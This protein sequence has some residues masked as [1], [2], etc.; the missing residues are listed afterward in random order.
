[1]GSRRG[2]VGGGGSGASTAQLDE[3]AGGLIALVAAVVLL[4]PACLRSVPVPG[5]LWTL[6]GMPL[7]AVAASWLLAGRE[8]PAI[9]HQ[10]LE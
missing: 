4:S 10:P 2:G 8:P 5:L 7:I 1:M 3:V 9:T 6:V